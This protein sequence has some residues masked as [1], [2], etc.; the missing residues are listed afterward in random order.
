MLELD[1]F[2]QIAGEKME[3]VRGI[4]EAALAGQGS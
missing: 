4:A 1:S 2:Q 3:R